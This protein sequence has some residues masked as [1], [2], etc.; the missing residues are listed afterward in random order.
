MVRFLSLSFSL[1]LSLSLIETHSFWR[2]TIVQPISILGLLRVPS[3]RRSPLLCH[4]LCS[5]L[6][7]LSNHPT[8]SLI[9]PLLCPQSRLSSARETHVWSAP[10]P[11]PFIH[12]FASSAQSLPWHVP[13]V[14]MYLPPCG[15]PTFPMPRNTK[16][17]VV[18]AP[19]NTRGD[20]SSVKTPP[21][22]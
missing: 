20:T 14:V 7:P 19:L 6:C 22:L 11:P 4:P 2:M 1:S 21:L 5:S 15:F 9:G 3:T 16:M 17:P 10:H 12:S 18:H 8:R 13:H